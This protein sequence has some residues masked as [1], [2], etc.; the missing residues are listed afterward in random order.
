MKVVVKLG[1]FLFPA[2]L[3]SALIQA[4]ANVIQRLCEHGYRFVVVTGGGLIARRYIKTARELG[5]SEYV[6]DLLGI[7]ASQLNA[8]LFIGAL[9]RYAHPEPPSSLNLI[10]EPFDRGKIVVVGGM[11]PAQSTNAVAALAAEAV[12]ADLLINAT[13]IDGVY[14]SDPR[15]D[16]SARKL[17]VVETQELMKIMLNGSMEAGTYELFD[18]VAIKVVERSRIKAYIIDGRVPENI[19]KAAKGETIGTIVL[20][21]RRF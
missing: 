10:H 13:N 16:P 7:Q 5:A 9:G 8:R 2:E 1:G 3:D 18:P 11:Q 4:Y 19:M 14:T 15:K 17:A 21:S 12:G 20:A 6:C